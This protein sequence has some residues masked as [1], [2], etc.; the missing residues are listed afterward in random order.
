MI[1]QLQ[2]VQG[3]R[4]MGSVLMGSNRTKIPFCT[5]CLYLMFESSFY[6]LKKVCGVGLN[7]LILHTSS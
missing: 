7:Y 2:M 4:L 6:Q 1:S 5:Y 3:H